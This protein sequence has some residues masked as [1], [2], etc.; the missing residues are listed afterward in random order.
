MKP[1][2]IVETDYTDLGSKGGVVSIFA[3]A[4]EARFDLYN[5]DGNWPDLYA[6]R[7]HILNYSN[8]RNEFMRQHG[9]VLEHL[10]PKQWA[11]L[12]AELM[13]TRSTVE[14]IWY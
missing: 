11:N 8:V 14:T 13:I 2:R 10:T 6:S 1:S 3:G 4:V 9:V 7:Q 12:L 5:G